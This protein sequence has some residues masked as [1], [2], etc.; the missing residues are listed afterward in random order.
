MPPLTV[1][2]LWIRNERPPIEKATLVTAV[3]PAGMDLLTIAE[4]LADLPGLSEPNIARIAFS[5]NA[6]LP[7]PLF[8]VSTTALPLAASKSK[9][10][11][12]P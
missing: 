1:N 4:G 10:L 8:P 7:D 12:G 2:S 9:Q 6:V 3:D 11:D 5:R